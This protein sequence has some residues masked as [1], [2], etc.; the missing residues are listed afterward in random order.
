MNFLRGIDFA[1]TKKIFLVSLIPHQKVKIFK[2]FNSAWT[3]FAIFGKIRKV[4]LTQIFHLQYVF[5]R[6]KFKLF[7]MYF[8]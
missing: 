1:N 3:C 2:K 4:I 8:S 7:F 6:L 5:I